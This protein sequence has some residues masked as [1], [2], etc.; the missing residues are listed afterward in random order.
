MMIGKGNNDINVDIPN[1]AYDTGKDIPTFSAYLIAI[2]R[3]STGKVIKVHKQKS[4][5]PT[6]NFIG[7]LLPVTWF[8]NT[9]SSF[10]ITNV[11]GGTCSY[12]PGIGGA[13]YCIPYPSSHINYPT[14]F[15][16][17]QVGSG[18]QPNP[19]SATSLA[20]PIANG[21]G[22]GQLIY[23]PTLLPVTATVSGNSAYFYI[24]QEFNNQSGATITVAEV[25]IILQLTLGNV[26]GGS[27]AN[28]GQVLL[29]YD[30]FSSPIS[31]P[32]NGGL[33]IYYTFTVSS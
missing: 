25:G 22:S 2:V 23:Y 29:W 15:I 30:V 3:D 33:A 19:S 18:S 12:K 24:L 28:C 1:D 31:I 5:S 21:S 16:M 17:I 4:H 10:T 26:N 14:Y 9:G 13:P 27:S 20:A 32:N 8:N 11:T 7:L 6:A